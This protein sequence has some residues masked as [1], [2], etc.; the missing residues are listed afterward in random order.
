MAEEVGFEPTVAFTTT[1][2]ETVLFGRSSTLPSVEAIGACGA[3]LSG[4]GHELV[5]AGRRA[6]Q[7]DQVP[8]VQDRGL[9]HMV[10]HPTG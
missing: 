8:C 4:V 6:R 7:E 2:F 5:E 3:T 10:E 9:V 1:V